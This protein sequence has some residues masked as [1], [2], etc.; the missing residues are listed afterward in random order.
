MEEMINNVIQEAVKY[1]LDKYNY[2]I[3][4]KNLDEI[5]EKIVP[6]LKRI[7]YEENFDD[8]ISFVNINFDILLNNNIKYFIE[9]IFEPYD[10]LY[11]Y[12]RSSDS[13]FL[14]NIVLVRVILDE[15]GEE[16]KKLIEILEQH[17][18]HKDQDD[19]KNS[20]SYS[21]SFPLDVEVLRFFIWLRRF[22]M[23]AREFLIKVKKEVLIENVQEG[24]EHAFN[25]YGCEIKIKNLDEVLDVIAPLL[26]DLESDMY[27]R[28]ILLSIKVQF[29]I[30]VP[31]RDIYIISI[32]SESQRVWLDYHLE[33][34]SVPLKK[35][36]ALVQ[37]LSF[38]NDSPNADKTRTE[39]MKE[40]FKRY[41][42]EV[43]H[44]FAYNPYDE[45]YFSLP[46]K[47]EVYKFWV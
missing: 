2:E 25:E 36:V 43:D 44:E 37:I 34:D 6:L 3:K 18:F 16:T 1:A 31:V 39:L 26:V 35:S 5:L 7:L 32:L 19:D 12:G 23:D 15:Y 30:K 45:F 29:E 17:G 40:V 11:N 28:E 20:I 41:N 46:L 21:S 47:V 33:N 13:E 14:E 10:D 24:I 38:E 27:I 9:F 4:I 8:V 42:I 22:A